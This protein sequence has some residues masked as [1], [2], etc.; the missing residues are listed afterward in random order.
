[1]LRRSALASLLVVALVST[2]V[3]RA[4]SCAPGQEDFY[5]TCINQLSFFGQATWK[6]VAPGAVTGHTLGS[7]ASGVAIDRSVKP[8]RLYVADT[9]NNRILGFNSLGNCSDIPIVACTNDSDCA[10]AA[11]GTCTISGAFGWPFNPA[12]RDAD[13][14]IGQPDATS[15]AC[16]GDDNVGIYGPASASSL[17]LMQTPAVDNIAESWQFMNFDVDAQGNLYV[18]D[19]HNNRVLEYNQPF[20][21][22]TTGGKGDGV[23]DLVFGQADFSSNL[24]NRGLDTP[25]PDTLFLNRGAFEHVA[26]PSFGGVMVDAHGNV[27]IG[28]FGNARVLRF[29]AGSTTPN[30]V[31]GQSDFTSVAPGSLVAP[32][33]MALDPANG[34][35]YVLDHDWAVNRERL[36][37]FGPD[38]ATGDF[39]NGMAPRRT[40]MPKHGV[41][42][43]KGWKYA[44]TATGL[45]LNRYKEGRYARGKIWVYENHPGKRA[46]LL[47]KNGHVVKLVGTPS[48]SKLGGAGWG[49]GHPQCTS[50]SYSYRLHWP[51]GSGA[52]D[53]DNNLY[54][55]DEG[56]SRVA[57][58]HLPTY[59]PV[60]ESGTKCP[61]K[62]DAVLL[63]SDE[64]SD[65]R[66]LGLYRGAH[67]AGNQLFVD[68]WTRVLVWNDY[69]TKGIGAPAD[70]VIAAD[71]NG[72]R[73]SAVDDQGHLWLSQLVFKLPVTAAMPAPIARDVP[74]YWA[75]DPDTQA[76]VIARPAFDPVQGKLWIADGNR[77]LRIS[78][79]GSIESGDKLLVDMVIGQVTKTA[80]ACN[81]GHPSPAA[82]TLCLA[83]QVQFDR[84]GNLYVVENDYECQGNDR[85]TV[86]R[87]QAIAAAQGMFPNLSAQIVF[88][89]T[90]TS[91]GNCVFSPVAVTF[92]SQ[93]HMVVAN[94]GGVFT[95]DYST[96]AV[97]QLFFYPSPLTNQVPS[98]TIRI[99]MGAPGEVQFDGSDNLIVRDH[100]WHRVWVVNLN[101]DPFWLVPN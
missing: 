30:L 40:R 66:L 47:D 95:P 56:F 28:D 35:L 68:D 53:D 27:W 72:A 46:V 13:V 15:S 83:E 85:I 75:D 82:N 61:P 97:R 51:G 70:I 99:P 18:T 49:D 32:F 37:V 21:T 33:A 88:G 96:R 87:A 84:L 20:N 17:C 81:Q 1:L 29:A 65:D 44:F 11:A 100:T 74:V 73:F 3:A 12:F 86:F 54:V 69:A 38:S 59:A 6:E 67:A 10:A 57:V 22:D 55:A 19:R 58:Y 76:T 23:A 91:P 7:H 5:G 89:G 101:L 92:D 36:V 64:L 71:T 4:Q 60:I 34:E 24:P 42:Y 79:A 62:P 43:P 41:A 98:A 94:D 14:I 48:A 25:G 77:V 80:N 52:I 9:T 8:H 90:F 93:N 50:S 45:T 2:G 31:L 26:T 63:G 16:N 39:T 78:N